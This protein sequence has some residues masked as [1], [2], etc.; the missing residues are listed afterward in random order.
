MCDRKV[1]DLREGRRLAEIG[2]LFVPWMVEREVFQCALSG[3][4]IENVEV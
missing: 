1:T 4:C 2:D 3:N